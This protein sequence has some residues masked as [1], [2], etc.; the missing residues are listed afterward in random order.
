ML[1]KKIRNTITKIFF[2]M[3]LNQIEK[4]RKWKCT[5]P[6]IY[7]LIQLDRDFPPKLEDI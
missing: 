7:F 3:T 1:K 2:L 6:H 5:F 4:Q